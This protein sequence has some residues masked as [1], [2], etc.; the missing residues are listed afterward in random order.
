VDF[1]VLR[2]AVQQ[3][4]LPRVLYA[5]PGIDV[6]G[7]AIDQCLR[8]HLRAL[9]GLPATFPSDALHWL[10][11]LWPSSFKIGEFRLK[12]A[13]RCYHQYGVKTVVRHLL[14]SR[15]DHRTPHYLMARGPLG[16]L[17]A[18][19][20]EHGLDWSSLDAAEYAPTAGV[21]PAKDQGRRRWSRECRA[22]VLKRVAQ[23]AVN[24]G[25]GLPEKPEDPL[26]VLKAHFPAD[27]TAAQDAIAA[28]LPPFLVKCGDLGRA[29]LRL[30]AGR[31]GSAVLPT[32]PCELC[33][34]AGSAHP[35]HLLQCPGLPE[36]LDGL[37]QRIAEARTAQVRRAAPKAPRLTPDVAAYKYG[38]SMLWPGV[39]E[40]L[41]AD[42]LWWAGHAIDLYC[43]RAQRAADGPVGQGPPPAVPYL[44]GLSP[45]E[46]EYYK[47]ARY[48]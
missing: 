37:R 7:A 1:Q 11:R 33:G 24:A 25:A 40:A 14:A 9:I 22:R 44:V 13:R 17:T 31:Y 30:L 3:V 20:Q 21:P 28:G 12:L 26:S 34:K 46:Y 8:A 27:E 47:P 15:R 5:A 23:W 18:A 35:A 29:G 32:A 42:H 6:D 39:S 16:L 43:V 41:L 45:A 48:G 10:L 38:T 2:L 19:L 4:I 36:D